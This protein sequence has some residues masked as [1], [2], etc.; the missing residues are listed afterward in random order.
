MKPRLLITRPA[1]EQQRTAEAARSA[2]F[3]PV[4]APLLRIEDLPFDLPETPPQALLF[5]SARAPAWAA[6]RFPE[7]LRTPAYAVGAHTAAAAHAAG[8]TL[9]QAG[10][11][12]GSAIVAAAA[13]AG[14]QTLLH[15]AGEDSAALDVPPGLSI[16]RRV[17][18]RAVA[19]EALPDAAL[20]ALR[21]GA[22]ALLLSPRTAAIFA[23]LLD[24]AGLPRADTALA[25][26]SAPA[27][28]AA[29]EGWRATAV[30]AQPDLNASLAAARLLWHKQGDG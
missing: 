14:E 4:A 27:A 13:K 16:E 17:I 2:G 5:T 12:D 19:A 6:R 11:A 1:A 25:L 8:F 15:L 30:A 10:E 24:A 9:R 23:V 20:E 21:G 26:I 22:I 28:R 29:G 7:L 18:Y 3:T